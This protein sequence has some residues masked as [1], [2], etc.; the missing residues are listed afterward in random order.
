[1]FC[2]LFDNVSHPMTA[3]SGKSNSALI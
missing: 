3:Q 2:P 1:M